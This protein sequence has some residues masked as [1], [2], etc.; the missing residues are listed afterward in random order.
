MIP[1]LAVQ[2][3]AGNP[4]P[5]VPSVRSMVALGC[6]LP[7]LPRPAAAGIK[8]GE[9]S[10]PDF[11]RCSPSRKDRC[12][13]RRRSG[14]PRKPAAVSTGGV[15]ATPARRRRPPLPAPPR[16]SRPTARSFQPALFI[17][18][19]CVRP[20]ARRHRPQ[21]TTPLPVVK[22][23]APPSRAR[24]PG[25]N[26]QLTRFRHAPGPAIDIPPDRG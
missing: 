2:P 8:M 19:S 6:L 17:R 22:R 14:S 7:I 26:P 10:T 15:R 21:P 12:R 5:S 18:L 23:A 25:D 11:P 3:L 4:H 1:V 9:Y 20:P 24:L 13:S 16:S